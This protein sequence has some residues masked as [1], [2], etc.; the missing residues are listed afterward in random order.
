MNNVWNYSWRRK[1]GAPGSLLVRGLAGMVLLIQLLIFFKATQVH[2][3]DGIGTIDATPFLVVG[4]RDEIGTIDATPFLFGPGIPMTKSKTIRNRILIGIISTAANHVAMTYRNRHRKLFALWNDTRVC[5]LHDFVQYEKQRIDN[6]HYN[7]GDEGSPSPCQIIYTFVIGG[8]PNGT[9]LLLDHNETTPLTLPSMPYKPR[10]KDTNRTDV[11]ILNIRENMNNGKTPT[12]FYFALQVMRQFPND[13]HYAMKCDSDAMLRLTSFLQF[14]DT[15]LPIL[16]NIAATSSSSSISL[17]SA[18]MNDPLLSLPPMSAPAV[19]IGSLRHKSLWEVKGT[20]ELRR[21][22]EGLWDAEYYNGV[23]LYL[24]GQCYAMSTRALE[25]LVDETRRQPLPPVGVNFSLTSDYYEGH[26]DHDTSSSVIVAATRENVT[27]RWIDMARHYRFWEHPVKGDFWWNKILSRE[28]KKIEKLKGAMANQTAQYSSSFS[29]QSGATPSVG[30]GATQPHRTLSTPRL[31]LFLIDS[32]DPKVR[33]E[34]RQALQ[35]DK[36]VCVL[37]DFLQQG[38]AT[39]NEDIPNTTSCEIVYTFVMGGKPKGPRQIV[40]KDSSL[41]LI[42][43]Q[44]TSGTPVENDLLVL[45][46]RYVQALNLEFG[47][48][49]CKPYSNAFC[50]ALDL[51]FFAFVD[52]S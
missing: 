42:I 40:R 28:T 11:T 2:T 44:A 5:S 47:G 25:L 26:E 24:A 12:F 6:S 38:K 13:I 17:T 52:P 45:N 3:K 37:Q 14:V 31:L 41:K 50:G 39:G 16:P 9:T 19:L 33:Q 30:G 32:T 8:N 1:R 48:V 29:S 46:I 51:I 7:G 18:S 23:H 22:Y 15:E 20:P 36:R 35:K 49:V 21:Q 27:L 4:E 34:H 43:P 10:H